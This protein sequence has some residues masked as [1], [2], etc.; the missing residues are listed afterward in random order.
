MNQSDSEQEQDAEA[1]AAREE[2]NNK[3]KRWRV[4]LYELDPQ[5]TW[6]DRGTGY[7]LQCS[8]SLSCLLRSYRIFYL[9]F[10]YFY[11]SR[12]TGELA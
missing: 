8:A 9:L 2:D 6:L 5:G 4:K 11:L 7:V 12:L 1:E 3:T 10:F